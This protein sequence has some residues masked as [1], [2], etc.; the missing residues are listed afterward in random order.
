MLAF[1]KCFASESDYVVGALERE[2]RSE[3]AI[4][5]RFTRRRKFSWSSLK[6]SY[7]RF[8]RLPYTIELTYLHPYCPWGKSSSSWM[9]KKKWR[10]R[11]KNSTSAPIFKIEE[12]HD[13]FILQVWSFFPSIFLGADNV[14]Q[15]ADKGTNVH[16]L[17][18]MKDCG[19]IMSYRDPWNGDTSI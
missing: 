10:D 6:Y 12:W 9:S 16:A 3:N 11:N 4:G 8:Y 2:W 18:H 5:L 13:D 1:Q 15:L 14:H 7:W 17:V 19:S